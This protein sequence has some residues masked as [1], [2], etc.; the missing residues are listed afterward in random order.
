MKTNLRILTLF[1]ILS[2]VCATN[3]RSQ[4]TY[5]WSGVGDGVSLA[6]SN[7]WIPI[8][9]PDGLKQDTAQ[10]NGLTKSNLLINYGSGFL[11]DTGLGTLGIT[12]SLTPNQTNSVQIISTNGESHGLGLFGINI[13]S[14]AGPFTLGDN[15][16]SG[17]RIITRP[18]GAIHH[19]V[20]N[21]TNPATINPNVL[22]VAAAATGIPMI[23]TGPAIGSSTATLFQT[24]T[25][26]LQLPFR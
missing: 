7:N 6:V 17:V 11:P 4:T 15:S 2:S 3:L 22:W 12:L 5:T 9:L 23:S 16:A 8:G 19:F 21:S 20:N 26:S 10:W 24:T 18:A 25:L 14:N 13:A 1:A